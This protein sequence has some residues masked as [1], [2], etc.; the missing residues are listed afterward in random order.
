MSLG[1]DGQ[2]VGGGRF[3][4]VQ[5]AQADSVADGQQA[6]V[7]WAIRFSFRSPAQDRLEGPID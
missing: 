1:E 4:T 2:L 5:Q 3:V 6:D 7:D